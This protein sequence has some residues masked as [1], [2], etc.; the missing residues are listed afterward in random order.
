MGKKSIGIDIGRYHVRAVQMVRTPEGFR[1]EKTFG[2]HT[3]RSTDSPVDI[4]RELTGPRGFDRKA[5]VVVSLPH[6]AVF[7][8]DAQVD[9]AT[10]KKLGEADPSILRD[11]FPISAEEALLQVCSAHPL[12]DERH[13]VLVAATAGDLVRQ[14]LRLL[15][16]ARIRPTIIETAISAA[17]TAVTVN[18]PEIAHGTALLCCVDESLLSLAVTQDGHILVVRN[19][20]LALPRGYEPDALAA[21]VADVLGREID[22]TWRKLYGADP[23]DNLHLY[24]IAAPETAGLIAT[25]IDGEMEGRTTVVDPYAHV[26]PPVAADVEYPLCIAEGLALR[27]LLPQPACNVNFLTPYFARTRPRVNI[28]R[29]LVTCAA[30]LAAILLVWTVGLFVRCARLESQYQRVES[31]QRDLFRRILPEEKNI[32]KP[33]AQLQQKL[34][35]FRDE[36]ALLT[37]F[38]PGRLTVLEVL[39]LLST[40]GPTTGSLQLDDMFI[41]ADAARVTGRANTFAAVSEWQRVL[42]QLSGVDIADQPNAQTD[43]DT[44]KVRFTL[45]LSTHRPVQ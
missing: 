11:S 10:L 20:P 1:V 30:F 9:A 16:E 43:D 45:S 29:E 37:S 31:E 22:I 36:S 6:H 23:E 19:I 34:D 39:H 12:V 42:D 8:A 26:A 33:L 44:G 21:E 27:A 15:S 32:G 7:F 17:H 41:A 40:H 28:R 24:L 38:Q 4:L 14:E 35:A 13:S 3:R 2:R 25:A 5:E 18:H